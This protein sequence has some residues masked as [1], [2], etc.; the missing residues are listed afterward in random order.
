MDTRRCALKKILGFIAILTA[1]DQIVK[2]IIAH[3][4]GSAAVVIIPNVL[5]FRPFQ[6]TYRLFVTALVEYRLPIYIIVFIQ[7]IAGV[8]LISMYR[9][10][11]YL[12]R[13]KYKL[14]DI[15]FAF[16]ISGVCCSFIDTVFWGG[17]LDYIQLFDWFIFDMKDVFLT[18]TAVLMIIFLLIVYTPY[19][20]KLTEEDKKKKGFWNWIKK[21]FPIK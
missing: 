8:I 13:A 17:S 5:L 21:G 12:L 1:I 6:N 9:Y 7:T 19:Y 10:F 18:I 20:N 4:Y 3:S 14:L 16:S 15:C 2:L 11:S